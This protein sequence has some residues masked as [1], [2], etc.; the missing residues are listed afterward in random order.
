MTRDHE[1]D[2]GEQ[3]A[4]RPV[5]QPADIDGELL[6][7]RPRQ[8]HAVVERMQEPGFRDP[9]A[10]LDQDAMHHRDLP[11]RSAEAQQ[12]D[13]RPYAD[14]LAE[15]DTMRGSRIAGA[16]RGGASAGVAR[17]SASTPP[18]PGRSGRRRRPVVRLVLQRAAP[19][20]ERVV[21]H[22]AVFEH[23]VVIGEVG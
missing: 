14:R 22:H 12:R 15:A 23:R 10:F 11:R 19:G 3:P 16:C 7:L 8:Q 17:A 20:V 2:T 9:A 21:H 4:G 5:H 13:P 18:L 6:R 1:Q